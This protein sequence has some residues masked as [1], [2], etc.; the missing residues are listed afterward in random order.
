MAGGSAQADLG[1]SPALAAL[2]D[3]VGGAWLR[4]LKARWVSLGAPLC[5]RPCMQAEEA[6]LG[7][8]GRCTSAG[9]QMGAQGA[10]P[11]L[12]APTKPCRRLRWC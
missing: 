2:Q 6:D 10:T 7:G 11:L 3:F 5:I 1:P 9:W 8:V 4:P 12:S